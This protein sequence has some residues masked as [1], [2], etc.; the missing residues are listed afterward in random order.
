MDAGIASWDAKRAYD[1]TRPVRAIRSLG[2][3]GLI[4]FDDGTGTFV[5]DAWGGVGQGTVRIPATEF[6]TYQMP[7]G[8]PSPPF[9]EYTSGHSAFSAAGAEILKRFT[10]SDAFGYSVAFGR[11]SSRFEVGLT[12]NS[13]ITLSWDTF[14]SAANQAGMSRRYGGI[15]FESGDLAGR[16]LG[17]KVGDKVWDRTQFFIGGGTKVPEPGAAIPLLVLGLLWFLSRTLS[18]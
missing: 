17:R 9:A 15:H 12:P 6:M 5:V 10:G 13:P 7:G 11:G 16:S 18:R 8:N 14:T 4:G 1:Y 3:L 2:R